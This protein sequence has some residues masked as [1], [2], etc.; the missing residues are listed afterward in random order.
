MSTAKTTLSDRSSR[1][2]A[3]GRPRG[4]ASADRHQQR[5][6]PPAARDR[7]AAPLR[8]RLASDGSQ[9]PGPAHPAPPGEPGQADQAAPP[10]A[11]RAPAAPGESK[12]G[13]LRAPGPRG[14]R[15]AAARGRA[16]PRPS[17]MNGRESSSEFT[18]CVTWTGV[19]SRASICWKIRRQRFAVLGPEVPPAGLGGDLGQ[20]L[21]VDLDRQH[22]VAEAARPPP[23]GDRAP[24][25]RCRRRSCRP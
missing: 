6:P 14:C 13:T 7:A 12:T 8:A 3:P 5:Q 21:L 11:A 17:R 19:F 10:P 20:Q 24:H 18:Y 4:P 16:E 15:R 2:P 1:S 25:P 9:R 23:G 22:L